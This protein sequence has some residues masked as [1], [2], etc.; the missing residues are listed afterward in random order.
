M[1]EKDDALKDYLEM[2]KKSWTWAKLTEKE[3]TIFEAWLY[4]E[5]FELKGNYKQRRET[6]GN[7]YTMFLL[8][9]GYDDPFQWRTTEEEKKDAPIF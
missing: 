3:K 7:Y 9:T 5:R 8:G 6:L 4:K 2:I 1:K